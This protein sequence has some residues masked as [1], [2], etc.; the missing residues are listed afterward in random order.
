M[1]K[2]VDEELADPYER[3][4]KDL[5]P[6]C[7]LFKLAEDP[8]WTDLTYLNGWK[9]T[10]LPGAILDAVSYESSI[11]LS[12]YANQ[13]LT[14]FPETG[15]LQRT[16]A[17]RLNATFAGQ[18]MYSA[19]VISTVPLD[20]VQLG[21]QILNSYGPG[22]TPLY[23]PTVSSDNYIDW[24]QVLWCE[25][26]YHYG[27]NTLSDP[28]FMQVQESGQIGSLSAT[29]ADKLYVYA[30]VIPGGTDITSMIIP[31]QRIGLIGQMAME[32]TIEYMMRLSNSYQLAN[33]V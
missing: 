19:T 28:G 7:N 14:F 29:A 9:L 20:M 8:T 10:T 2:K 26:N 17:F 33:Q 24:S 27:N 12:G 1:A 3:V 16:P 25:V 22:L 23:N 6:S 5:I 15:F 11:D 21:E 13:S 31:A 30:I 4:L 18:V 32:P